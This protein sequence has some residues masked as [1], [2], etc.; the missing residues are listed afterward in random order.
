MKHTQPR[1][2]RIPL[3]RNP[4]M[5]GV[6]GPILAKGGSKPVP[7]PRGSSQKMEA[8][9]AFRAKRW[10]SMLGYH[11]VVPR[12]GTETEM[13]PASSAKPTFRTPRDIIQ[14]ASSS[15]VTQ[16]REPGAPSF[17]PEF[18]RKGWERQSKSSET[19]TAGFFAPTLSQ[20]RARRMGHPPTGTVSPKGWA[21][22]PVA[23][24]TRAQPRW[25][26]RCPRP[27]WVVPGRGQAV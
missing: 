16:D 11:V 12:S 26:Y 13:V 27:S 23:Q 22:R 7:P 8:Y 1:D 24:K 2:L 5:S 18:R 19:R 6:P 10:R 9:P 21:T 15:C 4:R 25:R 3:I 20:K 14:D 17:A